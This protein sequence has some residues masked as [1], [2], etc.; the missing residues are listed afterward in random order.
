MKNHLLSLFAPALLT[1]TSAYA[2]TVGHTF[3]GVTTSNVVTAG[4]I[5][6]EFP[7]GTRWTVR[8]EWDATAPYTE[9]YPSQST[10]A[11]T[12]FMVILEGQTGNWTSSSLPGKASFGV[13][14]FGGAHELQFT[15]GWG[16]ENQTNP[17]IE[18]LAP[19]S[20][21]VTLT[22][23]TATA[24]SSLETTPTGV[25]LAK[26]SEGEFKFYLNNAGTSVIYGS[27]DLVGADSTPDVGVKQLGGKALKDGKAVSDFGKAKVGKLGTV[28]KYKI[29]NASDTKLSEIM[30][31]LTG[32]AKKDFKL[33]K[34]AVKSLKPGESMIFE[35]SFQPTAKGKRKAEI[36]I[37]GNGAKERAFNIGVVGKGE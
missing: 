19:Y 6:A 5:T 10:F 20:I 23:P 11:L 4:D 2:A 37:Y 31:S 14:Q 13:N 1:A 33:K 16:P 21:N 30:V 9:L 27:A 12:K 26:W 7:V 32:A 17:T 35:T 15:S 36:L 25:D 18:D 8:V 24:I 22:D 28:L 3:T 29:T 34:P